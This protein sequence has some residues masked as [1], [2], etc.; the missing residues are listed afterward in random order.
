[1]VVTI[2]FNTGKITIEKIEDLNDLHK[3]RSK[4]R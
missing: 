3:I 2:D 1:M 4:E